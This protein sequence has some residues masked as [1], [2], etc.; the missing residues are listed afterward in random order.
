M[1]ATMAGRLIV[2]EG[3]EGAGKT[4]QLRRLS[5]QLDR[6]GVGHR[7][8]REPGGT[9]VGDEIR[10][11]LLNSDSHLSAPAEALLFMASRAE[12]IASEVR[13][14]LE[15]GHWVLLDRFFLSTYA[16]QV[17]G[18]GLAEAAVRD[19]NLLAT[20]GLVP[21]LTLLLTLPVR[22]GLAR[23]SKRSAPDRIER[24]ATEFHA[25][26]ESAFA[27]YCVDAWQRRHPEAGPIAVI[28]ADGSAEAVESRVLDAMT[29]RFPELRSALG[30]VA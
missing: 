30:A 28:G 7:A 23:A 26:V 9:P 21:D 17:G 6:A 8:F 18:R 10:G 14:A 11:I 16:Y 29:A 15:Q 12:L 1:T 20:G 3:V 19:A 5:Q 25:R 13:P 4:T 27:E 2:F 22:E 24:S